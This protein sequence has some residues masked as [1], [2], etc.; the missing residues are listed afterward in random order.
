MSK[1]L[2]LTGTAL[3]GTAVVLIAAHNFADRFVSPMPTDA[4]RLS[5][6]P[7]NPDLGFMVAAAQADEAAHDGRYGI[8]RP[9][10]PEELAAWDVDVRPDGQGLPP[11]S[12]S[13]M[14]GE[15]A[16]LTNCAACHGDFAEGL[17]NWP[18]LSGGEGTLANEDPV[19]TIGSYW[20]YLSTVWDYV[21]RSM[22]YGNAQSLSTDE[23]Y[24]ITAYLLYSNFLVEDDFV[25]TNEN[26]AEIEMPNAD[27][28]I[29][30]DRPETEYTIWRTEPC[31]ENCK[32]EAEITLRATDL[33]VTPVDPEQEEAAAQTGTGSSGEET[34]DTA[35]VAE[36]TGDMTE[37]APEAETAAMEID[38]ALAEDG[39]SVFR[40][41]Q[42][43]HQVGEDAQNRTG[44]HLNDLFGRE[45]GGIDGFRYSNTLLEMGEEGGVWNEETLAKFLANPREY[46][47]R[48]KMAF[49]GLRNDEDIAAVTEYLKTYSEN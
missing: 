49:A 39:E 32:D 31:M 8:G 3:A 22:P 16:Y 41:C 34:V 12:G 23:V 9:A 19:K 20:P 44:P 5:A 24:A 4:P 29:I 40:Q 15:E 45:M 28:F 48:T 38:M 1:S 6:G 35:A 25:L 7:S 11:G 30:D 43:C 2:K 10:A 13:V 46:V 36:D 18:P 47:Q 42:A 26:F 14:E 17:G 33:G 27:G 37:T 21:H